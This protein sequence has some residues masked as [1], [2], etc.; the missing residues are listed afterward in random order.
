VLDITDLV[1]SLRASGGDTTAVEVKSGAG[2][3]S[4]S[5]TS[6][7]S[8]LAN[9]PGGGR[10]ILGLDEATGFT[11]VKLADPQSLKQGLG[12]MARTLTPP[13]GLTVHDAE[14][15]GLPVIVAD[16]AECPLGRSPAT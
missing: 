9:L 11:P 4:H 3:L 7:L 8:A 1:A 2:G 6:S 15:D 10:V 13:V 14:V 5:L 16:V 12:S